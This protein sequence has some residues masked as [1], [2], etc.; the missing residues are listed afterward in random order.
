MI[1]YDRKAYKKARWRKKETRVLIR[2]ANAY[3]E[4]IAVKE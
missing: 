4:Q 1:R 3:T 2:F